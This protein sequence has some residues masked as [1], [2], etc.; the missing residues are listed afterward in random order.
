MRRASVFGW[1]VLPSETMHSL[2]V[3]DEK[4]TS[5]SDS[6][7]DRAYTR[8]NTVSQRTNILPDRDWH[9]TESDG[10]IGVEAREAPVGENRE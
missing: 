8:W 10:G 4:N 3:F 9:G 6:T 2:C 5:F 1:P 7:A